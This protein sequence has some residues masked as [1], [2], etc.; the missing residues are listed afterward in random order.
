MQFHQQI[1][2]NVSADRLWEIVGTNFTDV[3]KW[4]SSVL[5]SSALPDMPAGSGRVCHV[6]GSGRVVER[7]Y[8]YDDERREV[9]FTL[10]GERTPFF[11]QNVDI[12][13]RVQAQGDSQAVA[14]VDADIQLMPVFRQL[15]SRR[16]STRL[17][18][19]GDDILLELKHFAETGQPQV[20]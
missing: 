13:W 19:R 11:L 8:H 7:I 1:T 9:A 2:V 10:E 5:E 4:A 17:M 6:Q 20:A 12:T 3:S 18:K 14:H 16:L 15:L